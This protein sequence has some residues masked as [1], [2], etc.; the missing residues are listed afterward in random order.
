MCSP[1]LFFPPFSLSNRL[2]ERL[3]AN[4]SSA[5]RQVKTFGGGLVF[6]FPLYI[7]EV[8]GNMFPEYEI[9]VSKAVQCF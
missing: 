3:I 2:C 5:M 6:F 8:T 7:N 1:D 9:P 4:D